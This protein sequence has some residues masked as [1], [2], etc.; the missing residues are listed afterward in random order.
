[1]LVRERSLIPSDHHLDVTRDPLRGFEA[2]AHT[3]KNSAVAGGS[4]TVSCAT[5]TF[6]RLDRA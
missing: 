5:R 1:M 6:L 4:A 2:V 3:A